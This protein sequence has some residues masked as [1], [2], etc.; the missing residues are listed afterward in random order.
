[1][2]RYE[3]HEDLLPCPFCG[4]EAFLKETKRES[5]GY[6]CAEVGVVCNGCDLMKRSYDTEVFEM[7]KGTFSIIE[8]SLREATI[9]WNTRSYL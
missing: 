9:Q 7:G 4:E 3:P 2:T 1:M 5:W 6:Y 8:K